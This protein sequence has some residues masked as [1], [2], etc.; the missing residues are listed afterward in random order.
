MDEQ[1]NVKVYG[2]V[3]LQNQFQLEMISNQVNSI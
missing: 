3:V 1:V 2:D